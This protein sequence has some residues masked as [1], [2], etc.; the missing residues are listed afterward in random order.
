M[1]HDSESQ[2]WLDALSS[3]IKYAGKDRAAEI[4]NQLSEQAAG[5]RAERRYRKRQT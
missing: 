4:L 3:L 1:Q 2:E 5:S